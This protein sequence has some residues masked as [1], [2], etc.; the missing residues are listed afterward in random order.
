MLGP[1]SMAGQAI[2]LL[3][4]PSATTEKERDER[5]DRDH[6]EDRM[7]DDAAGDRDDE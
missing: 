1:P 3:R 4:G 7:D 5:Q 6:K 2:G